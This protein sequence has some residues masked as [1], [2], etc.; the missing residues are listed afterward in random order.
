MVAPSARSSVEVGLP[1]LARSLRSQVQNAKQTVGLAPASRSA[2]RRTAALARAWADGIAALATLGAPETSGPSAQ[3]TRS[4]AS[5][6]RS[7]I[8]TI[9]QLVLGKDARVAPSARSSVEVGLP[10][11]ARSPRSQVQ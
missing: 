8:P 9:A 1:R 10:R 4:P 6:T 2:T 7:V 5:A 3:R 11:L